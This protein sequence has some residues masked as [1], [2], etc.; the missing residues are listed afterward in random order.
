[1][2]LGTIK[3]AS[4]T[5]GQTVGFDNASADQVLYLTP[6]GTLATLTITLPSDASSRL[7]QRAVIA[8]SQ[9]I[10]ALTV[11]GAM[12]LNPMASLSPN[13]CFAFIK[14]AANTWILLQ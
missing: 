2:P 4:P 11:S 3:T 8:T 10:T 6:G 12:V 9:A 1:M 14:V 13:D 7:A 5:T